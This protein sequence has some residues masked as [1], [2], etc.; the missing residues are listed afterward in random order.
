[1]AHDERLMA[2][3]DALFV[4]AGHQAAEARLLWDRIAQKVITLTVDTVPYAEEEDAWSGLTAC[5]GFAA[6][7]ACLVGCSFLLGRP[8]SAELATMWGWYQAGHWPCGYASIPVDD[9]PGRLL[10]Y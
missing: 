2:W 8:V 3:H 7:T 10:V 4:A 6:H 1:M 5:V 9:F